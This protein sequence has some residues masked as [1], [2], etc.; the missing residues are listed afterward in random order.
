MSLPDWTSE[1]LLPV[2]IHA[3]R[4]ADLYDRFVDDAP[5]RAHR[6]MLFSALNTYMMLLKRFVPHGRAWIDGGFATRKASAP[7][8][9]DVVVLPND[10]EA[11]AALDDR[12][13]NDFLGLLTHQDIIVGS[14]D[15]PQ[16]WA[17]LQPIGGA[18]DAFLCYPGHEHIW[19]QTWAS[20][21]GDDGE[22]VTGMAKGFAEVSW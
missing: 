21:K 4:M 12:D 20:V 17:R 9:V 19:E 22:I 14:F 7:H 13:A 6:E 15:P 8:D 3:G 1:G 16:W 2:G 11:V 10:W 18:L 5:E